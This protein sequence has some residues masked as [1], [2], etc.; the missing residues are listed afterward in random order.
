MKSSAQKTPVIRVSSTRK[1]ISEVHSAIQRALRATTAS[2]PRAIRIN[3][4]PTNGKK[5]TSERSGQWLTA[6]FRP[7]PREQVPRHQ[8]DEADHHC[9]GVVIE[10]PG[11]QPAGLVC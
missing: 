6:M 3:A 5:V 7:S 1:A 4:A 10:I 2:S 9:E 8:G 11:L